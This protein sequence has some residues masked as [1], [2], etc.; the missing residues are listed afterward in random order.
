MTRRDRHDIVLEILNKA[1]TGKKKT[2]LMKE[3]GLSFAQTKLYMAILREKGLLEASER[4]QLKTTRKG[5]EML[6]RCSDC[7][8]FPWKLRKKTPEI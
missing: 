3:V 1:K 2:D 8:I 5:M 4:N 7:L 6:E